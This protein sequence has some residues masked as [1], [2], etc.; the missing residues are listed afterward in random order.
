MKLDVVQDHLGDGTFPT[1]AKGSL[2]N[3]LS[4]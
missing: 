3:L 4:A 1:F 2:V